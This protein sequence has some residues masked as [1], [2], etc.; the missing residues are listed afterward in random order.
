MIMLANKKDFELHI[1]SND[2]P[3]NLE[4]NLS[5]ISIFK[6]NIVLRFAPDNSYGGHGPI[7]AKFNVESLD[8]SSKALEKKLTNANFNTKS[9][10]KLTIFIVEKILDKIEQAK[11]GSSSGSFQAIFEE[12]ESN[13]NDRTEYIYKYSKLDGK[14]KKKILYE[15]AILTSSNNN[16]EDGQSLTR[17]LQHLMLCSYFVW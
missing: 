2:I 10:Q 4:L 1:T 8:D 14:A 3:K 9:T 15:A 12:I 16:D 11:S 7:F 17:Q 13:A 6:G 5:S